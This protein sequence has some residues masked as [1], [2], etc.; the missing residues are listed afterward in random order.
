MFTFNRLSALRPISLSIVIALFVVF[1]FGA[2]AFA[3][4]GVIT[5]CAKRDGEVYLIGTGF[6]RATFARGDQALRGTFKAPRV[7]RE[8]LVHLARTARPGHK[9]LREINLYQPP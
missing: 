9:E 4:S 8:I 1:S 6:Q 5:A 3:T 7:T 2:Y